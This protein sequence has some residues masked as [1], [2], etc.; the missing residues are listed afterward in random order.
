VFKQAIKS[1][2]KNGKHLTQ[3]CKVLYGLIIQALFYIKLKRIDR[4]FLISS[5][6]GEKVT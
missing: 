2:Q 4:F 5:S 3:H 1:A 6:C